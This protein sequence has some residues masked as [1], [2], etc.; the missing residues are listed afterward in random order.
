MLLI[1]KPGF[2]FV[3]QNRLIDSLL[4]IIIEGIRK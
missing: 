1:A 3:E 2:P 4:D